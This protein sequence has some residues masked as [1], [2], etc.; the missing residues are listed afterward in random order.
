MLRKRRIVVTGIM[1]VAAATTPESLT[2]KA[3]MAVIRAPFVAAKTIGRRSSGLRT[4]VAGL[5]SS[6]R[7]MASETTNTLVQMV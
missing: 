4:Q 5:W 7:V 2:N 6:H 1:A 3:T